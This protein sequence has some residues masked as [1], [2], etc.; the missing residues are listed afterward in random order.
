MLRAARTHCVA[1]SATGSGRRSTQ[2][3]SGVAEHDTHWVL[4]ALGDAVLAALGMR[5]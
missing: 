1:R 3:V 2:H 5:C 4:S